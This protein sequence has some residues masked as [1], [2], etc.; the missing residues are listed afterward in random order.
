[1]LPGPSRD[2]PSMPGYQPTRITDWIVRDRLKTTGRRR[3]ATVEPRQRADLSGSEPA[4]TPTEPRTEMPTS[5][6]R[7]MNFVRKL[8]AVSVASGRLPIRSQNII[9]TIRTGNKMFRTF[10]VPTTLRGSIRWIPLAERR[11]RRSS[12]DRR[13]V[14]ETPEISRGAFQQFELSQC[15]KW[16]RLHALTHCVSRHDR[17]GKTS[18]GA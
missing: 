4:S 1:M 15:L 12:R 9:R 16:G 18:W 7:S 2:V 14:A 11:R 5:G 17:W 13:C 8:G 6:I 3:S 10:R